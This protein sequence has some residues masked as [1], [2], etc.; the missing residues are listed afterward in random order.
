MEP[1]RKPVLSTADKDELARSA[2]RAADES[3]RAEEDAQSER[4]RIGPSPAVRWVRWMTAVAAA[5]F[6]FSV[7][8]LFRAQHLTPGDPAPGQP[9]GVPA[10]H[11][12][13]TAPHV[14]PV[15]QPAGTRAPAQHDS[16]GP[17]AL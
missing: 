17:A 5:V 13:T 1:L 2:F 9:G 15:E 3:D 12:S 8:Q 4:M 16:E 7:V 11:H 14:T 6:L 10:V